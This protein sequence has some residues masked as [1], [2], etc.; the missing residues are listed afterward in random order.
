MSVKKLNNI[1]HNIAHHAASGLS[2]LHP[3]LGEGCRASGILVVELDLLNGTYPANFPVPK[4]LSLSTHELINKFKEMIEDSKSS[5]DEIES[6]KLYFQFSLLRKDDYACV[7]K[8][9][10]KLVSGRE[11]SHVIE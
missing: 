5:K 1:A 4:P 2:Y 6:A 9:V 3:Y 11:L 8:S 10:L 7:V